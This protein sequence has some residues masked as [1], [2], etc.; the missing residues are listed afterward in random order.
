M[1]EAVAGIPAHTA[2][3]RSIDRAGSAARRTAPSAAVG[4][5]AQ[6]T[7]DVRAPLDAS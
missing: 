6:L 4:G 1:A 2:G 5:T 7:P 3:T